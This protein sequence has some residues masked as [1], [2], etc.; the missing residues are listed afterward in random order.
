VTILD[1]ILAHKRLE[2]AESKARRPPDEVARAARAEPHRLRGFTRALRSTPGVCVIAEVK[3]RSPSKGLI[4]SDF[5][6]VAI[7][8]AYAGAGAAAISVLTDSRYFGGELEYLSA[9]RNAVDLPLLR[10]DF[11]IDDY[12]IDESRVAG[13]D[14]ILLIVAA[15][16]REDLEALYQHATALGLDVLVEVHD[17]L[18][19]EIARGLGAELIGVNNRDLRSFAVDLATTERIAGLAS[20]TEVLV[21]AESGI[22]SFEDVERLERAGAGGFLVGESLMRQP[23]PGKALEALRRPS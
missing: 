3:R 15:L 1:E 6:P 18:E 7:A 10:K 5:D 9:I 21:I 19:W 14:A 13:A 22:G 23:D 12:Q 11:V 16:P 8:R 20:G 4:R 2:V 17:E